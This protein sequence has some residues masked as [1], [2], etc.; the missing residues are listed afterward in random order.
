MKDLLA[1]ILEFLFAQDQKEH[2]M[3]PAAEESLFQKL[4]YKIHKNEVSDLWQNKI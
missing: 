1:A 3:P 2:P 4:K